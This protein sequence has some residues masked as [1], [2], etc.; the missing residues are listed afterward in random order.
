MP[1]PPT[2]NSTTRQPGS[3]RGLSPDHTTNGREES[4]TILAEPIQRLNLPVNTPP[5]TPPIAPSAYSNPISAGCRCSTRTRKIVVTAV[6]APDQKLT[7]PVQA[8]TLRRI[9]GRG[10]DSAGSGRSR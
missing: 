9:G 1:T 4:Q 6:E 7:V 2:P 5:S 3:A 8:T 10:T